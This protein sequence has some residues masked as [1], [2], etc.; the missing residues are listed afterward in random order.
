MA[1]RSAAAPSVTK[2]ASVSTPGETNTSNNTSN[3]DSTSVHATATSTPTPTAV[4]SQPAPA[5][6]LPTEKEDEPNESKLTEEQRQQRERTNT[7][8]LDDERTEGNV[9]GVRCGPADPE[10]ALGAIELPFDLAD[11]PYAVIAT[12]DG[13]LQV[14]LGGAAQARCRVIQVGDYL[15]A[16][17]V[18]Q[19]EYLFDADDVTL[20]RGGRRVR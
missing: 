9:V 6:A 15:E 17:G 3:P 7:L 20:T 8:G 1:V 13:L 4:T 11:V 2:T 14:R 16:E 12:R 10:P 5:A 19:H 18:K